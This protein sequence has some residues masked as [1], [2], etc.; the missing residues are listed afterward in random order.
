ML[1]VSMH[2]DVK[3]KVNIMKPTKLTAAFLAA[4]A[5]IAPFSFNTSSLLTPPTVFA[6]DSTALAKLPDWIPTDFDSAT[7]FRNTY[8]A[9]HIENG[10][11]CIVYPERVK[12]GSK[13]D[14]FGYR[15]QPTSDM[16][17]TLKQEI[18]SHDNTET[19][20]NVF[21]YQPQKQGDL[22]LQITDPYAILDGDTYDEPLGISTYSF[23]VDK[24]LSITETD[25]YSWLPD[26][27]SEYSEYTTKHGEVSV[28]DNYILFC[29]MRVD[30]FNDKWEPD[31]T[32]KYENINYLLSSDCTMQVADLYDDGSV[33][34]I[35]V[36]Q[37]KK[38]GCE[39]ISWTR[40]SDAGPQSNYTLTAD[41]AI[42]DNAQTILLPGQMR[43]TLV[44]YDTGKQ[45]ALT[46]G[47]TP[48]IWTNISDGEE[49][50]GPILMM[51]TNPAIVDNNLGRS[52]GSGQFSFGLEKDYLP[53]GYTFLDDDSR[54][55]YYSGTIIP[56]EH[57]TVS[58]YDNGSANIIF[59]LKSSPTGDMNGDGAFTV[60]DVILLQ[61]WL[62][63]EPGTKLANWKAAD[64]NR[65]NLL[66][67]V[68]LSMMKRALIQVSAIPVAVQV[69]EEGGG[70]GAEIYNKVYREGKTYY[71]S[72][73]DLTDNP[74][75]QPLTVRISEQDYNEIM[76]QDY[77]QMIQYMTVP[78]GPEWSELMCTLIVTYS[79]GSQKIAVSERMPGVITKLRD[80]QTKYFSY[81]EPDEHFD[82]GVPFHV[83]E[84]GLKFYLGPDES[85]EAVASLPANTRMIERGTQKNNS[86]WLFTEYNGQYG[87]INTLGSDGKMV[88][89]FEEAAKK[90]VIYLY[91]EQ[92]T[93][94][95]IE[96]KLTESEL[97]TTYP[98]YNNGWN[99][100]AYPDGTLLNQADGSHHRYLFWDSVNCSTKF[101]FSKGFCVEGCNTEQ[102]LKEKLTYM[103]LNE[104][105]MNEF[106]VYWLP[107]MEHNT[108]NLIAFQGDEYTNSAKLMITPTPDSE[109]RIFMAYIPLENAVE[110]EP[111]QLETFERTGFAVVE[112]G[113][114][115]IKQ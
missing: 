112:W 50:T 14:T 34:I 30:Q 26:S 94:V 35:Y 51:E 49:S 97:N 27:K 48:S 9:T 96:L 99:V 90:P 92:E 25:I 91:P 64:F 38:D 8:G 58:K 62:T 68:D 105:E 16:G 31:S 114:V 6:E 52:I 80:L 72:Y 74:D 102:F 98:K 2:S 69:K 20:F 111:Q 47:K 104:E 95:H 5:A 65:D 53:D 85:Y 43:A 3:G 24:S 10:L 83:L 19:C 77:E 44:D 100:T 63:A 75:A 46:E 78:S 17:Q 66:N 12:K 86:T 29:T 89:Y 41:C 113:G 56:E 22:E 39:K 21:V 73:Q 70:A 1:S 55:G 57:M 71:L 15:L 37:A 76:S 67:A 32:N 11:I 109:I 13:Q 36:Y 110:I 93:D 106:I 81:V 59:K 115:E 4:A 28:K 18:Y 82:Y 88:I 33:D 61:K 107:L 54:S 42:L 7:E 87:W 45:I 103:G 79:D 108:Y 84:D 101:D 40:T 23:S 60:A